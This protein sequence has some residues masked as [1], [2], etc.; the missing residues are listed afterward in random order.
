MISLCPPP[1]AHA[2]RWITYNLPRRRPDPT[3]TVPGNTGTNYIYMDSSTRVFVPGRHTLDWEANAADMSAV[4]QT[5]MLL[6]ADDGKVSYV[7]YNDQHPE[8]HTSL[9]E[10]GQSRG[11]VMFDQDVGVWIVHSVPGFPKRKFRGYSWPGSGIEMGQTLFCVSFSAG[12]LP[13]VVRQLSLRQVYTYDSSVESS[14]IDSILSGRDEA[15]AKVVRDA[16]DEIVSGDVISSRSSAITSYYPAGTVYPAVAQLTT[17]G[18]ESV[19]AFA[20]TQVFGNNLYYWLAQYYK[21]TEMYVKSW[22]CSTGRMMPTLC[23]GSEAEE[24]G[25]Y[26]VRIHNV[27]RLVVHPSLPDISSHEDNSK[28]AVILADPTNIEGQKYPYLCIADS[29]RMVNNLQTDNC[30]CDSSI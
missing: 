5:L 16:L 2:R 13:E 9:D 18:G 20:K 23:P 4:Q 8:A 6:Y 29:D 21:A 12:Y 3:G 30:D 24:V 7:M 17:L 26:R 27:N 15:D 11:V 1:I 25:A 19:H 28:W 22:Q 14:T 10:Y